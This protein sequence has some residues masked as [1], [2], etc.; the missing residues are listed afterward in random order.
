MAASDAY[1]FHIS[2]CD[3]DLKMLI[4]EVQC[5]PLNGGMLGN[6]GNGGMVWESPPFLFMD[7]FYDL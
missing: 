4:H 3:F 1:S 7:N 2:T 6:Y 5:I